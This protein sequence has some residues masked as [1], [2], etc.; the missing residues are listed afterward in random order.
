MLGLRDSAFA[1]LLHRV[2]ELNILSL[3]SKIM[4]KMKSIL[5]LSAAAMCLSTTPSF[6]QYGSGSSSNN[7]PT[8]S[9]TAKRAKKVRSTIS[10]A[11]EKRRMALKEKE[12]MEAKLAQQEGSYGSGTAKPAESYGSG[13]PKPAESYGS[14]TPKPT[15]SYGSGTTKPTQAYGS[16][17]PKPADSYGSGTP[18]PAGSYGSGNA[19]TI[20]CPSGTTAQADGTC[21]ITSGSFPTG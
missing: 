15:E 8:N 5:V 1:E 12:A 6:A 11:D 18:K 10:K 21:L 9:S 4:S 7:L 3:T 13:T 19:V 14:G 20:N 2:F 17:T 16:G